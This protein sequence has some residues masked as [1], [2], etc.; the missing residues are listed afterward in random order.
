ML[1]Y[2]IDSRTI[3]DEKLTFLK[4][5]VNIIKDIYAIKI[6]KQRF[7]GVSMKKL[8]H[9]GIY[10]LLVFLSIYLLDFS[11]L[12]L[13]KMFVWGMD[14]YSIIVAV[15]QLALLGLFI[16]WLKKKKML[17][18]FEKKGSK[19]SRFFYLLVSLVAAY[20]VRQLLSAFYLQF[21]RFINNHYIFEDLLSVLSFSEQSTI[22]TTCFSFIS[23]VILGP[24]LEELVHRGYFM[25]SFFPKSKYYLDVILSALIFGLSHLVLSHR[26]LISLMVYSF[27]GFFFA[28][29][30]RWTKSLKITIL[31]HSFINFLIHADF[32][33]LFLSNLIYYRFFR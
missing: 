19:K 31:C 23:V 11:S 26:D 5:V 3:Q 6:S 16:Y 28:L 9:L 32:I 30:Y 8:G 12:Y 22:L 20:F 10:T 27:F 25:N 14:G 29:V 21:S 7:F 1:F 24:I 4:I 15:E 33:W 18:I 2:V 17:Y 13:A